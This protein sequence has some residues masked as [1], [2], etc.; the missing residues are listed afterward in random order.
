[1]IEEET[2]FGERNR[3][4]C[5][6]GGS[7]TFIIIFSAALI[8]YSGVNVFLGKAAWDPYPFIL[9][10]LFLSM[11]T[12]IQAS[13]NRQ[14]TKDRP[15]GELDFEVNRRAASD[16]QRLAK[17]MNLGGDKLGDLEDLVRYRTPQNGDEGTEPQPSSRV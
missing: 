17:K 11:L 16:I 4:L 2:T 6:F 10:N 14:D 8:V 1:M 12:A 9:L 5:G 13:K 7:Q 3:G 15:H